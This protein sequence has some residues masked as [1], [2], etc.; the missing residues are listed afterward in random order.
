MR[1]HR[2]A[3]WAV[4]GAIGATCASQS[5]FPLA[6]RHLGPE[7][8]PNVMALGAMASRISLGNLGQDPTKV[9]ASLEQRFGARCAGWMQ[10]TAADWAMESLG[11]ARDFVYQLG[12]QSTDEHDQPAY[13]LT[14]SISDR[15]IAR[16]T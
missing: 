11:I 15:R 6:D 4:S 16:N 1:P 2:P 5:R 8:S 9:A 14:P 10:G 7:Q 3:F 13:K 12:E